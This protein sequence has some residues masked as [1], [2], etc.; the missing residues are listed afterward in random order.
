M[1]CPQCGGTLTTAQRDGV[2]LAVCG[3]CSG[4]WLTRQELDELE[5]EAY[6]LGKKGSLVFNPEPSDRVCPE[7]G[8]GLEKFQYRDYDLE[9]E[10]CP[11][12]HGFWLEA[13][14]DQ[15]VLQLMRQ[16]ETS[17]KRSFKAEDHWSGHLRHWRSPGFMEKIRDLLR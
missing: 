5:N 13:G 11:D 14:Q 15:R 4:M 16:E 10:F 7:C 3:A 1:K 6:D 2:V 9:L 8:T 17:L 12:G